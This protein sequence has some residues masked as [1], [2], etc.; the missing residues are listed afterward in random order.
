MV[1]INRAINQDKG[2]VPIVHTFYAEGVGENTIPAYE[3]DTVRTTVRNQI[4]Q[5]A[6]GLLLVIN[7]LI[8]FWQ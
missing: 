8:L 5:P 7:T 2:A 6:P 3:D 1:L 4:W